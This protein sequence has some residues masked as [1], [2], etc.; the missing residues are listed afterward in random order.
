MRP[1]GVRQLSGKPTVDQNARIRAILDSLRKLHPPGPTRSP[2][3]ADDDG[4]GTV[5]VLEIA[6][7]MA[8]GPAHPKRSCSL[9]GT[10]ARSWAC[11][12]PTGSPG[13]HGAARLDRGPAQHRH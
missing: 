4:S 9:S 12:A 11:S 2:T 6:E 7:A 10:P 3:G 1:E 13:I 5:S 8:Q